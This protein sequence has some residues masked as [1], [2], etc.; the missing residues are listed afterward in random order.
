MDV[1]AISTTGRMNTVGADANWLVEPAVKVVGAGT[2]A[3][4]PTSVIDSFELGAVDSN[5]LP[6]KS[7]EYDGGGSISS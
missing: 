4:A 6:G 7:V 2:V 1:G 3:A 5:D